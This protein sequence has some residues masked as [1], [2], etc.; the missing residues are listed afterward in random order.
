MAI[1]LLAHRGR[2]SGLSGG[3]ATAGSKTRPGPR[4]SRTR[5][6]LLEVRER[7]LTH[8]AEQASPQTLT[9]SPKMRA[10][11]LLS[12]CFYHDNETARKI[13]LLFK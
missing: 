9:S 1:E 10:A 13:I 2:P 3:V 5:L 6:V 7:R 8:S 12:D 4:V 11:C